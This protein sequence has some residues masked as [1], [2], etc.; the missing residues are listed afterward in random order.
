MRIRTKRSKLILDRLQYAGHL[1]GRPL[2]VLRRTDPKRHSRYAELGTPV[3]HV[4][5]FLRSEPV[6]LA[7]IC[8]LDLNSVTAIAINDPSPATP[9]FARDFS[10]AVGGT[11]FST[12]KAAARSAIWDGA[13][14]RIGRSAHPRQ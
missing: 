11:M 6:N 9:A 8:K 12:A 7:W 13:I 10:T 14:N 1:V 3:Q 2:K 4:V 5:Q